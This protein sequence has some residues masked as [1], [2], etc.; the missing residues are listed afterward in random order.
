M[1]RSS[2]IPKPILVGMVL[3]ASFTAGAEVPGCSSPPGSHVPMAANL[4][5][6]A[7]LAVEQWHELPDGSEGHHFKT[8][9]S[10]ARDN[11][12]RVSA[13]RSG[14][15]TQSGSRMALI[16][17]ICDP[18]AGTRTSFQACVQ[19]AN[20]P[21]SSN[22]CAVE[23]VA[24][25][26]DA[27]RRNPDSGPPV[28]PDPFKPLPPHHSSDLVPRSG[29]L[30]DLGEKRIEGVKVHGYRNVGPFNLHRSCNGVPLTT[31]K[32]W[33]LSEETALQVSATTRTS[34]PASLHFACSGTMTLE[35]TNIQ[36]V[37]PEPELFQVPSDYEIVREPTIKPQY[38]PGRQKTGDA[39][40]Q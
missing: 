23:K 19:D 2:S 37:E 31:T 18:I 27:A 26:W 4:P 8:V 11:D 36:Q 34:G 12:G 20:D 40:T 7:D 13:K 29:E 1:I 5:F 25:V 3:V 10:I 30:V 39:Q 32:E 28:F 17:E 6:T 22:G 16:M 9:Y 15:T 21:T 14:Y 24:K 33:W 38:L 35:L